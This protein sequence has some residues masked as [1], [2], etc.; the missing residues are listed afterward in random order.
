MTQQ[1]G[2]GEVPCLHS[3][4]ENDSELKLK[5]LPSYQN[6]LFPDK[7]NIN[8]NNTINDPHENDGEE[9]EA[10][11][12]GS[13]LEGIDQALEAKKIQRETMKRAL[14]VIPAS[15]IGY[16]AA[17]ALSMWFVQKYAPKQIVWARRYRNIFVPPLANAFPF[18]YWM[19]ISMH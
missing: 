4:H 9:T 5:E 10:P 8:I 15:M 13:V 3:T 17:E 18:H 11:P 2:E 16:C 7:I 12:R 19:S 6:G 14:I 1:E